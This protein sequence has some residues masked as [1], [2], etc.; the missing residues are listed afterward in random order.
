M[1]TNM[2][3]EENKK[4]N[5]SEASISETDGSLLDDSKDT[6]SINHD[7]QKDNTTTEKASH[8]DSSTVQHKPAAPVETPKSK[9]TTRAKRKAKKAKH[10]EKESEG[11]WEDL[12]FKES[13]HLQLKDIS[14]SL[15][16]L[17]NRTELRNEFSKMFDAKMDKLMTT[18]KEE[19]IKSVTHRIEVL[20]GELHECQVNNDNLSKKIKSTENKLKD[21]ENEIDSL[22]KETEN[23]KRDIERLQFA[24]EDSDR[25]FCGRTNELEQYSRRNNIRIWGIPEA[26]NDD[27]DAQATI[28]KVVK[29]LNEKMGTNLTTYDID[30][31]HRIGKK[32][33]NKKS[34]RCIIVKFLSRLSK[35]KCL[36]NRK[37]NLK[38]TNI[39][40]Q[41]DLTSLNYSVY[42]AARSNDEVEKCW[43]ID[44]TVYVVMKGSDEITRIDYSDYQDWLDFAEEEDAEIEA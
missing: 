37:Q 43:T 40:I 25:S 28:D 2:D 35:I 26:Q 15:A 41:E 30:I 14:A 4:R 44:G 18:M 23:Q 27:E 1:A 20:E 7:K 21:K 24:L 22:K 19:I 11:E 6:E 42:M 12:S 31:A 5:R 9:P 33:K 3:V 34:G 32:Q 29:T 10:A 16:N 36:K 38:G 17:V 39:F 8:N 13:I